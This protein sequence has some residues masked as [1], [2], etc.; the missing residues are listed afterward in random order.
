[1]K[2]GGQLYSDMRIK[3]K[4]YFHLHRP[5]SAFCTGLPSEAITAAVA[6]V[7]AFFGGMLRQHSRS[8]DIEGSIFRY[9]VPSHTEG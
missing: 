5:A 9:Y 6:A 8:I 3:E 4:S 2:Y 1:M 7:F